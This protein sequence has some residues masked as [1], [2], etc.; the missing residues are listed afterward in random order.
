[1]DP[2]WFQIVLTLAAGVGL[3]AA[4][5]MRV[6]LPM[7]VLGLSARAGWIPIDGDFSWLTS[8]TGLSMLAVAAVAEVA[9]YYVPAVDNLLDAV[10]GP[11]A[12][13]AG[14][15]VLAAVATDLPPFL[16]WAVAIAAGGGTAGAIQ[17]LTTVARLKSTGLTGGLA[18]PVLSTM[19]L[20]G[21]GLIALLSIVAPLVAIGL[22]LAV[23]L[24]LK[25]FASRVLGRRTTVEAGST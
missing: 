8:T 18:N 14:I 13:V 9:G 24:V 5:G 22:V 1:M 3:A 7:L 23:F 11:A 10:A 20:V 15:L 12:F 16:R 19:E 25:R 6:F 2:V 17:G 4:A 21:A